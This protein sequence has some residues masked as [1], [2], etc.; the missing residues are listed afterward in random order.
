MKLRNLI[1]A[2]AALLASTN[3][4]FADGYR[5]AT[6][7]FP[8]EFVALAPT[9]VAAGDLIPVW[10]VS[11]NDW[12]K[13]TAVGTVSTVMRVFQ[14]TIANGQ[15]S[16]TVT[17]TGVTSASMCVAQSNVVS[18][19]AVYLRAA[20]PG[21]NQVVITSSGDPGASGLLTTVICAN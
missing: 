16:K 10:D 13:V 8:R 7:S 18:T 6:Q 21:T 2:L 5:L 9:A 1:L 19:N 4:V 20:V 15:T 17:A 12:K 14:D 11:A 3:V